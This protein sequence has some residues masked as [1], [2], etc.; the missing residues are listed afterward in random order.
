MGL[1]QIIRRHMRKRGADIVAYGSDFSDLDRD[2]IAAVE[3]FTLTSHFRIFT[4]I[5]AVRH[6]QRNGLE[7]AFVECGVW[8]GGSMMA[9][10]QAMQAMKMEPRDLYLYDTFEGMSE[11]TE[12]DVLNSDGS[13]SADE[14]LKVR[15][16]GTEGNIWCDAS[17]QDVQGN[18]G[19][20]GYPAERIHYVVGKVEDTL[21]A[22]IPDKIAVLRLDTDWYESTKHELEQLYPRL[23]PG[24]LLV[25]DDYG[26]WKGAKDA[27]DEY[28]AGLGRVPFLAR[29]DATGRVCVKA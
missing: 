1:V 4:M 21:P 17:L 7:G 15:G 11:P 29:I 27:V 10:A 26:F 14:L 19:K 13:T 9:V 24:G 16:K 3:P 18:M 6:V 5:E 2:I 22:T 8:R 25:I 28:F 23:V 20:T 12:R